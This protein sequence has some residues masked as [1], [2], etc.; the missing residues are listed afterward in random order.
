M[1]ASI[2]PVLLRCTE[3]LMTHRTELEVNRGY[4]VWAVCA[5]ACASALMGATGWRYAATRPIALGSGR[6]VDR[7][8]GRR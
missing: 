2:V 6:M 3:T 1:E 7:A 5:D 4:P 8:D